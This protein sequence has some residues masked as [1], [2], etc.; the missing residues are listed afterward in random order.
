MTD[1]IRFCRFC[2]NF[3]PLNQSSIVH[4][5]HSQH[6]TRQLDALQTPCGNN[7]IMKDGKIIGPNCQTHMALPL[8]TLRFLIPA[9]VLRSTSYGLDIY[10]FEFPS[11]TLENASSHSSESKPNYSLIHVLYCFVQICLCDCKNNDTIKFDY[12]FAR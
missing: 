6:A 11:T 7:E 10:T 1:L 3:G 5:K 12:D 2:D 9:T 4:A 8:S